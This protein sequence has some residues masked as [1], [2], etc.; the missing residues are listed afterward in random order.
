MLELIVCIGTSCHLRGAEKVVKIFQQR[1]KADSLEDRIELRGTFCL[2]KCSGEKVM[3]SI[4]SEI[5][6]T[7]PETAD[8]LFSVEIIQA[9]KNLSGNSISGK[10]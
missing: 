10:A 5:H 6:E 2:G 1:I 3:V 4:N 9:L 7:T 8:T